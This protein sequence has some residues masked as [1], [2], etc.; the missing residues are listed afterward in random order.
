VGVDPRSVAEGT[1]RRL[2]AVR[3]LRILALALALALVP[4]VARAAP[5]SITYSLSGT[6]GSNGWYVSP[7][8][9]HWS[10][11][12]NIDG[13]SSGCEPAVRIPDDTTGTTRTCSASGTE[14]NASV[15][16]SVI[17]I[18]QTPPVASAVA[19]SRA[20][21]HD[22]W[23][24]SPVAVG[25]SGTDA[26]SGIDSCTAL[27]YGGPDAAPAPLSGTCHDRAGNTSAPLATGLLFDAT[28]PAPPR[29]GATAGDASIALAWEP[30]ADTGSVT[31]T[32]SPGV[33]GARA[34]IVYEGTAT[35][36]G[37]R[38]LRNGVRYTYTVTASD[39]AGNVAVTSV[40]ATPA[41]FLARPPLA[42]MSSTSEPPVLRWKAVRRARY[43]NV[44]VYRGGHRVLNAWPTRAA[45]H[46]PSSWR[47]RN[48]SR[49]L[50]PGLYRWYV[51]PGYGAR[52]G[53][54]YGKLLG[55]SEF[56]VAGA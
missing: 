49:H 38:R 27:A 52:R 48:R 2:S 29:V 21:D 43:Y 23:F 25:W 33:A 28:P 16:T 36:V 20:P 31:V 50:D 10:V 45:L 30:S 51:W 18:D 34:T 4:A 1:P 6:P 37:D 32:R 39:A 13:G 44:Q 9:V 53:R 7:V 15:T 40:A 14:G 11:S 56:T 41:S 8:T 46:V 35:T 19:T 55:R 26:T 54:H 24:T 12:G 42:A 3:A 5:P 17:R 47:Y 22:G